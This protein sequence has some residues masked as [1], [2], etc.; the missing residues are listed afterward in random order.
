MLT[1]GVAQVLK[2]MVH[3]CGKM[4]VLDEMLAQ[5]HEVMR[6]DDDDDDDDGACLIGLM[7]RT[8][9]ACSSSRK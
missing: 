3:G 9:T 8:S 6:D 5:L 7:C 1:F 2:L 4:L